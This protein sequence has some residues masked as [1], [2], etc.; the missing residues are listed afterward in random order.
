MLCLELALL[1]F[2]SLGVSGSDITSS[3]ESEQE[4]YRNCH[5][6]GDTL[7]AA[8]VVCNQLLNHFAE[9]LKSG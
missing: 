9:T 8:H 7:I 6:N 3:L 5:V 1:G 2:L 4:S